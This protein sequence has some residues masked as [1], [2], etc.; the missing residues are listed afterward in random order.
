MV[1][2][3]ASSDVFGSDVSTSRAAR[4][5]DVAAPVASTVAVASPRVTMPDP[6]TAPPGPTEAGSDAREGGAVDANLAVQDEQVGRRDVAG[7]DAEDIAGHDAGRWQRGPGPVTEHPCPRGQA[8]RERSQCPGRPCGLLVADQRVHDQQRRDDGRLPSP[9]RGAASG[10]PC[11]PA[12]TAE[13]PRTAWRGGAR[14]AWAGPAGYWGRRQPGAGWPLR[15]SA[16]RPARWWR[17]HVPLT[18]RS[19]P[20]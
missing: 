19:I 13:V 3:T 11:L 12:S 20:E 6:G 5:K 8:G 9:C 15:S 1:K 7:T 18:Y 2:T 16:R 17:C 10:W 4:P 14:R